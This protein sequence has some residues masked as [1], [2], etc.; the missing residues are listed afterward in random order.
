MDIFYCQPLEVVTHTREEYRKT[1]LNQWAD[2]VR[3]DVKF[4][5]VDGEHYMMI[6][7][8]CQIRGTYAVV[9]RPAQHP[10][11]VDV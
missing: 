5:E 6:G 7:P 11:V 10:I 4:E 3:D 9:E 1:K 8:S 2:F